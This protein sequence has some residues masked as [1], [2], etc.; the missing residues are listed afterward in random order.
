MAKYGTLK[1]LIEHADGDEIVQRGLTGLRLRYRQSV[2]LAADLADTIAAPRED[3]VALAEDEVRLYR[4]QDDT[5]SVIEA[6]KIER[7]LQS[8]SDLADS[9]LRGRYELPLAGTPRVLIFN[10]CDIARYYL[11][12]DAATEQVEKRYKTAIAWLKSVSDGTVTLDSDDAV[13]PEE[14][15][16]AAVIEGPGRVFSRDSM[17]G[18]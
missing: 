6:P 8:A 16:G 13:Q 2:A 12:D 5:W 14:G 1:D 11:Y 10:V 3:D 7:V 18:L 9:Y 4:Y 17:S 15:R